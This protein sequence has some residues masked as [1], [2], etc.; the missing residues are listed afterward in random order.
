MKAG[1]HYTKQVEF[2]DTDMGGIVHF[3]RFF[4][5]MEEAEHHFLRSKGLSIMMQVDGAPHGIPRVSA[6]CDFKSPAYFEDSL[7]ITVE[8]QRLGNSSLHY[9]FE[10]SRNETLLAVG[11]LVAVFCLMESGQKPKA[12][13]IP[14][15]IRDR[16]EGKSS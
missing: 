6:T 14:P 13:P 12:V 7:A 2:A 11:K 9:G 3:S 1:F 15:W 4:R 5:Y 10:I 16:L 8:V